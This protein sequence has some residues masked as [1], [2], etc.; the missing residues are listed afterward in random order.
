MTETDRPRIAYERGFCDHVVGLGG[1]GYSFAE[2]A[3]DLKITRAELQ[4]W[5]QSHP[6]FREAMVHARDRA[7]AWWERKAREGLEQGTKLN[8]TVWSK[9][10][11]A[12][13]PS[14][15]YGERGGGDGRAG[16]EP[17]PAKDPRSARDRARAIALVL[18]KARA[19]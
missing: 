17:I 9:S 13:F 2:I 3:D 5:T 12:R 18:A 1:H 11:A 10:I 16:G 15:A 6:D 4:A 14:E 19:E 8:T 7:L